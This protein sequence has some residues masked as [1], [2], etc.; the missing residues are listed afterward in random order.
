MFQITGKCINSFCSLKVSDGLRPHNLLGDLPHLTW[1]CRP[2]ERS[3]TQIRFAY[4]KVLGVTILH[5]ITYYNHHFTPFYIIKNPWFPGPQILQSSQ[6]SLP[7]AWGLPR[8]TRDICSRHSRCGWA[9]GA[10][11][12]RHG[13]K[14]PEMKVVFAESKL[15][16]SRK[17][18]E[19]LIYYIILHYVI[20]HYIVLY[21]VL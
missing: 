15:G 16:E 2:P 1:W 6:S 13:T 10:P 12:A 4:I 18:M 21:Y 3:K 14:T 8:P 19:I 17:W 7:G 5:T 9:P 11:G 20:L